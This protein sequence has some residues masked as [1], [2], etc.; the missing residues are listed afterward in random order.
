M[1]LLGRA[2]AVFGYGAAG[3]TAGALGAVR[4]LVTVLGL[5]PLLGAVGVADRH[6][7][8]RDRVVDAAQRRHTRDAAAGADDHLAVDLLAQDAVGR[9]DVVGALGRDRGRLDRQAA[10][11]NRG[12]GLGH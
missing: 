2:E 12:G 6:A 4:D 9:A 10:L 1:D 8:H 3:G 11:A 5:A 7:A